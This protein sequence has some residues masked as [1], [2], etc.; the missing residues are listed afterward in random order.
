LRLLDWLDASRRSASPDGGGPAGAAEG[1]T[2]VAV[3]GPVG[4]A[5]AEAGVDASAGL[6]AF[7]VYGI[8]GLA[9]V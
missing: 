7:E 5:A 8:D 9:L 3:A 2:E 4:A 1:Q 6:D